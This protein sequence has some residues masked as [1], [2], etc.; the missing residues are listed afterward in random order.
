VRN[1]KGAEASFLLGQMMF[2]PACGAPEQENLRFS[3]G[4]GAEATIAMKVNGLE[5]VCYYLVNGFVR[6]GTI[7]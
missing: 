6:F 3:G 5:G 2:R 7:S 4:S 1:K